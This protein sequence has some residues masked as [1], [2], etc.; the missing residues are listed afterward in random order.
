M[1]VVQNQEAYQYPLSGGTG[2]FSVYGF[3]YQ[4]GTSVAFLL[5]AFAFGLTL[6]RPSLFVPSASDAYSEAV[7]C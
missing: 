7:S 3:E 6:T 2:D 1:T 5:L 4:P